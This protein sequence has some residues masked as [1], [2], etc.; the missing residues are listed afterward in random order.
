MEREQKRSGKRKRDTGVWE[1]TF[2]QGQLAGRATFEVFNGVKVS[3]DLNAL[4]FYYYLQYHT[5]PHT[6]TNDVRTH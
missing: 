5:L 6:H 1:G 4:N 2:D 3:A